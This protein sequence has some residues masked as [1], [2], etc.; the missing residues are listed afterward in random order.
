MLGLLFF[1]FP[2]KPSPVDLCILTASSNVRQCSNI[3]FSS[4][5]PWPYNSVWISSNQTSKRTWCRLLLCEVTSTCMESGKCKRD[6][7]ANRVCYWIGYMA[8]SCWGPL[9]HASIEH[10]SILSHQGKGSGSIYP[11]ALALR[12]WGLTMAS[13]SELKVVS[14][15]VG[16]DH[17]VW[18]TILSSAPPPRHSSLFPPYFLSIWNFL[19]YLFSYPSSTVCSSYPQVEHQ[20]C[21]TRDL[22]VLFTFLSPWLRTWEPCLIQSRLS[23]ISSECMNEWTN[24]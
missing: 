19:V 1:P 10:A 24:E 14:R 13:A 18:Y 6:E 11:L 15:H 23:I 8:Q 16:G 7:Q 3:T 20:L 5:H 21:K 22:S 12:V 4:S 9:E 17:N 2:G